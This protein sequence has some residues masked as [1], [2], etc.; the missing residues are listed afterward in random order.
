MKT[1]TDVVSAQT[2]FSMYELQDSL[3]K[4]PQELDGFSW[5][6]HISKW[7]PSNLMETFCFSVFFR[8][9]MLNINSANSLKGSVCSFYLCGWSLD[10]IYA[11]TFMRNI[12]SRNQQ[13]DIV[14]WLTL[15]GQSFIILQ[16]SEKF[17]QV[18]EADKLRAD[19]CRVLC[20]SLV[21]FPQYAF[22]TKTTT[23]TKKTDHNK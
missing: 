11:E 8:L 10:H 13:A 7:Q 5:E 23:T 2:R 21:D 18:P 4:T 12:N 6:Q 16:S 19:G 20:P 1:A 22:F 17:I 14:T 3:V 9:H 15:E